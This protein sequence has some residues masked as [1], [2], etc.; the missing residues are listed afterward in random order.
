METLVAQVCLS[1]S[2]LLF[3][4][5]L[6]RSDVVCGPSFHLT[7]SQS[8]LLLLSTD[9]LCKFIDVPDS[10]FP[11][12]QLTHP[13]V[14]KLLNLVPQFH[15]INRRFR[16]PRNLLQLLFREES[17]KFAPVVLPLEAIL[18][19]QRSG[20]SRFFLSNDINKQFF[21]RGNIFFIE[22]FDYFRKAVKT[23]TLKRFKST[24]S[25]VQLLTSINAMWWMT[26]AKERKLGKMLRLSRF[27]GAARRFLALL[28][29][30]CGWVIDYASS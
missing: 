29:S 15:F 24:G 26:G 20:R 4:R 2:V 19:S 8:S 7:T 5:W 17:Y 13:T 10:C 1:F 16:L 25:S 21:Y 28:W 12:S 22:F 14:N 11:N 9:I 18:V 23:T 30:S 3:F 27:S 6:S